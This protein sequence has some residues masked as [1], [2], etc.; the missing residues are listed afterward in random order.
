[1]FRDEIEGKRA[2]GI[3]VFEDFARGTHVCSFY[4]SKKDLMEILVPYFK[5]GIEAN[6]HLI[7]LTT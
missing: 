7:W 4:D 6:E 5:A 2:S 3:E 1:M